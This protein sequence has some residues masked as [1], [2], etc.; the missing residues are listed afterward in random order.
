MKL[1][2]LNDMQQKAVLQTEGP[3]LILA[4]AGSG[5]TRVLTHRIAYL[6]E[7]KGIR[8]QQILAITFTNKAAQ[9]MKE[10]VEAQIGVL[11][12]DMW[13]STFHSTC[14]RILRMNIDKLGYDRSFVIYDMDDQ[15][16]LLKECYKQL[17]IDDKAWPLASTHNEISSSKDE[18]ISPEEYEKQAGADFRRQKIA[19]VYHLYQKKLQGNNALDFDD[20]I[21]KTVQLF[22]LHPDVLE[23]YQ[24]RF[25]YIMVDEY[26]DTNTSQYQL[27]RLLASKYK[28]LCVVGD[29]DQSIYKFRGAN[30]HN[31]LDFE[32][33]FPKALV[34]KL[35]QNYRCSK[36]ILDA[37]NQVI[38]NNRGR[39]AKTL[40]TDNP[41]GTPIQKIETQNEYEEAEYV[42]KQI[43]EEIEE[44]REYKHI[45]LLYRTNAQSRVLEEKLIRANI[46]YRLYGGVRFYE[47]KEIKDLIAY[48][49]TIANPSDD[50]AVQRII[51]VPKRGI[52]NTTVDRIIEFAHTEAYDFFDVLLAADEIPVLQR[53]A[54][55]L[56]AF[57]NMMISFQHQVPHIKLVEL[58]EQILK[59]TGYLQELERENTDESE[60]RIE[61]IKEFISKVA[62]YEQSADEPS[63]S[64]LL[65]EISLVA[66]IDNYNEENNAVSLMTLHS[67]KGL[68]FPCVFITG[69][70]EGLFPSYMSIA[71]GDEQDIEEE[72]RL[73]YVGITRAEQQI[74]FTHA[75]SRMVRGN[76]QYNRMSR[77]LEEIPVYLYGETEEK[78]F[79][80]TSNTPI[81]QQNKVNIPTRKVKI[82]MPTPTHF[83][84][85]FEEGDQVKHKKF[86]QGVVLE[87]RPAGADYEVT[88]DF[89]EK[90][91][92]KL[93][94]HLSKLQKADH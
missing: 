76:T 20:L 23:Y 21:F 51:N 15:K 7:E 3:V 64:G 29:D 59:D 65:E 48:L 78:E 67:A 19:Q 27:I 44:G 85:T 40:W 61:N 80:P 9:E 37:A 66:D 72:R 43:I 11:C 93:M 45:A 50:I 17:N 91:I 1:S 56:K 53:A 35:E 10:R 55:K 92:K 74:Y 4:G 57:A 73:C 46:P 8:P 94:A 28:N 84:L 24:D 22:T 83:Q 34:I 5:K 31:I 12:R 36:S 13:V 71:S 42:A 39:K 41:E 2:A 6:I 63:L 68:E 88:V 79:R 89:G 49:R 81:F 86:G 54:S 52:G 75:R 69:L 60:G 87:I 47:R 30:I 14:V 90:G 32:K 16:R 77:F 38:S 25:Q 18:L 58:V 82:D 70:E 26:Q 62:D 33:D